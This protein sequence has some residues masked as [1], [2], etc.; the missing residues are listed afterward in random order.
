[1]AEQTARSRLTVDLEPRLRRRLGL[2]ASS[3]RLSLAAYV[4]RAVERQIEEDI[5][6]AI[7]AV[8]DP[9]LADLW[10]NEADAVYD[11]P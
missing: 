7:Y 5:P 4:R 2:A 1:M 3:R 6:P 9:V 8:D 10:D 11:E